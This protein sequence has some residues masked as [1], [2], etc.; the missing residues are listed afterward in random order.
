[1]TTTLIIGA[2]NIGSTTI[3]DLNITGA[4]LKAQT[5]IVIR[6]IPEEDQLRKLEWLKNGFVDLA[7]EGS[8]LPARLEA[9]EPAETGRY[10]GPFQMRIVASAH[11]GAFG[12]FVR[13]DSR[14]RT[15]YDITP[16]TRMAVMPQGT[17]IHG[18][19]AWLKLYTG[20]LEKPETIRWKARLVHFETYQASIRSVAEGT[21]DVSFANPE[22]D[23][24]ASVAAAPH[25]LRFLEIPADK[26]PEG[27][28]RYRR[29][30]PYGQVVP[31]PKLGVR[32]IWGVKTFVGTANIWCRDD[33]NANLAYRLTKWFDEAYEQYRD[34]GDKLANYSR[35][36]FRQALNVAM[37]PVHPGAVRYFREI[38]MW[39]PADD[40]R[41][42][43]NNSVL[44]R[45]CQLWD[46]T[47]AE[48]AKKNI[49]INPANRDW[50]AL[51][52]KNKAGAGVPSFKQMTDREITAGL[53]ALKQTAGRK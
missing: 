7:Y 6:P 24:T 49:P 43:Y 38:G 50:L 16:E 23:V 13:G 15:I 52:A 1:M 20:N 21:A 31:A 18:L 53:A 17:N 8:A 41:Q 5:G 36:A 9:R 14:I 29:F 35:Q 25:G 51:W 28:A 27:Y 42:E 32:E 11:S 4:M 19:L 33:F 48:A 45:Y 22:G 44:N 37:V 47:L 2:G 10:R 30:M 12:Y 46:G 40:R 34:K 39:K 26:D 3:K